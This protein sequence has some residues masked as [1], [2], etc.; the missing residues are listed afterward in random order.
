[1]N[2]ELPNIKCN[3]DSGTRFGFWEVCSD[4]LGCDLD[5]G[6]CFV[7]T[8]H[9]MLASRNANEAHLKY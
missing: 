5:S 3:L 7:P 2:D 9:R 1:M 4:I 6:K 8:S